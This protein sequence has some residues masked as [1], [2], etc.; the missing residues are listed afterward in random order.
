MNIKN[1]LAFKI[2]IYLFISSIS[3]S[4]IKTAQAFFPSVYEPNPKELEITGRNLGKTAIQLIYFGEVE[5]GK[6]LTELAISLNPN[7]DVL[8]SIL[9][10]IQIINN[11][12][13]GARKSIEKAIRINPLEANYLFKEASISF[14]EK[15][16][17]QSIKSINK[18]LSI[19]PKNAG[20]YFQL[21]NCKIIKKELHDALKAFKKAN[22]YK[23]K[24]WQSLNNQG[25]VL[26]ELNE[27]TKAIKVWQKTISIKSDAEPMLALA[28]A[29]YSLEENKSESILLAKEA[30]S[31]NPKYVSKNHQRE[32]LWGE[33]LINATQR[34]FKDNEM[35]VS[36]KQAKVKNTTKNSS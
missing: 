34:L 1:K 27:K 20:G 32:Q 25:L 30:L 10:E 16:I 3:F 15:K 6:Q 2:L 17:N 8:W 14:Q 4:T 29:K 23:P 35:R 7:D 24:F 22:V 9:T 18:G 19:N 12:L 26:Y 11:E 36:V 5:K 31:K 21:G 28:A 33:K 13:V